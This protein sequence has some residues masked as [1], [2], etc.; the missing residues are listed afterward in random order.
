MIGSISSSIQASSAHPNASSRNDHQGSSST[1][2]GGDS[3]STNSNHRNAVGSGRIRTISTS[4]RQNTTESNRSHPEEDSCRGRCASCCDS[5]V[6]IALITF[7]IFLIAAILIG[8]LEL[9]GSGPH[10][11]RIPNSQPEEDPDSMYIYGLV[12]LSLALLSLAII[13]LGGYISSNSI[14]SSGGGGESDSHSAGG[15][16]GIRRDS[17]WRGSSIH[18]SSGGG[19]SSSATHHRYRDPRDLH[20]HRHPHQTSGRTI[21]QSSVGASAPAAS[22]ISTVSQQHH[23]LMQQ[24]QMMRPPEV[25]FTPV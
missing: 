24:Q 1:V 10:D 5:W 14:L 3:A 25:I 13:L 2:V 9:F 7:P 18:A 23:Q 17:G 20:S 11:P 19:G 8:I 22:G 21:H 16:G 12:F 6:K 15:T 4:D